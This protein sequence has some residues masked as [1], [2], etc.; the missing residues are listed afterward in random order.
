MTAV[1]DECAADATDAGPRPEAAT[2]PTAGNREWPTCSPPGPVL[3]V[4]LRLELFD[5][6]RV[7]CGGVKVGWD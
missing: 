5:S 7:E 3:P 1:A 2:V 6:I 4:V